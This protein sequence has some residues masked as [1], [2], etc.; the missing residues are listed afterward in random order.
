MALLFSVKLSERL[1]CLLVLLCILIVMII[2]GYFINFPIYD[3]LENYRGPILTL[4]SGH[5]PYRPGIGMYVPPWFLFIL[6]PIA[7]LPERLS[8]A[9]MFALA[10]TSLFWMSRKMGAR[11]LITLI[12]MLSYPVV[13]L[14]IHRQLEWLVLLGYFLPPPLG[15]FLVL[16]KPQAGIGIAIYW[17]IEGFQVG[18]I[19]E[20]IKRFA[21]V[22][23]AFI[24]SFII[25]GFY[26]G[27]SF[28]Q[29]GQAWDESIWPYGI[30]MGVYLL[31]TAI[32]SKN[33]KL[34]ISTS[35]FISP[36]LAGY[37]WTVGLFGL[38]SN[39][40][41]FALACLSTWVIYFINFPKTF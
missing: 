19:W 37:T 29:M 3:W 41:E 9:V 15:L 7:V 39:N 20:I 25:Y 11:L 2:A 26:L 33:G 35:P 34:S 18:G 13:T 32:R 10:V 30:P 8:S 14:Y 38:I 4:I 28:Y 22:G 12:F 21:P 1:K 40:I 6:A 36:Y 5:N 31:A 24:V 16:G 17:L 27:R 23:I